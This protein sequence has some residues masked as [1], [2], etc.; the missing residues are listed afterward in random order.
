MPPGAVLSTTLDVLYADTLLGKC[1][2]RAIKQ[3]RFP[4]GE[5]DDAV[6]SRTYMFKR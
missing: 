4:V 3:T 2:A 1:I 6:T 5:P